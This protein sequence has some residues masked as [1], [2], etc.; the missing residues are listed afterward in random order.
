MGREPHSVVRAGGRLAEVAGAV[1]RIR[2]VRSTRAGSCEGQGEAAFP[3]GERLPSPQFLAAALPPS[4]GEAVLFPALLAPAVLRH[5]FEHALGLSAERLH[6]L[7]SP[8]MVDDSSFGLP[9]NL[10]GLLVGGSASLSAGFAR[11]PAWALAGAL[12]SAALTLSLL[13][14]CERLSRQLRAALRGP[15]GHRRHAAS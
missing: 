13:C 5:A 1:A 8:P 11:H 12:G 14:V 7:L 10:G 6:V 3:S 9:A 4:T 15:Q 2:V